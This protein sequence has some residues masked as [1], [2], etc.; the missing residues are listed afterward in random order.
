MTSKLESTKKAYFAKNI[1]GKNT[2][3]KVEITQEQGIFMKTFDEPI[4]SQNENQG[5]IFE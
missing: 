3:Q 2:F 1:K 5:L 4:N